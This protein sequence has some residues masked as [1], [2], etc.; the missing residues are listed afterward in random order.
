MTPSS[1][2]AM[3]AVAAS[4]VAATAAW[5][6]WKRQKECPRPPRVV[7]VMAVREEGR[8]LERLLAKDSALEVM[9]LAHLRRVR[10]HVG[11]LR[12]DVVTCGIGE[13]DAATATTMVMLEEPAHPPTAILSVGCAGAHCPEFNAGDVVLGTAVVPMACKMVRADGAHEHV[14]HRLS[15]SEFVT[16]LHL[17]GLARA[18]AL[19]L[20]STTMPAWPTAP[21]RR[22]AIH[23]GKV[24]STETWTQGVPDIR[25][26]H[27]AHGTCCEEM[28]AYGVVRVAG[29]LGSVPVLAIKDIANNE[30]NPEMAATAQETGKGESIILDEIGRRASVVAAATLAVLS[31][32]VASEDT[33]VT[34]ALL[35]L[36]QRARR[37]C[38]D[39]LRALHCLPA[40]VDASA[41]QA[42]A[43]R[44]D[45]SEVRRL[46]A[47]L[48]SDA[49][50]TRVSPSLAPTIDQE[51]AMICTM[52]A[53]DFG[54]GWRQELHAY[55]GQGAWATVKPGVERL[56]E[57]WPTLPA[58]KLSALD[59]ADVSRLWR[60]EGERSAP[61]GP[62]VASLRMVCNELGRN[63]LSRGHETMA[64]FVS[65]C[66]WRHRC[67]ATPASMLVAELVAAF[68]ATFDDR[69]TLRGREVCLYKKAQLVVGE[70]YH[71]FRA[72]DARFAFGDGD[73]LTAFI[74]NVICAVL[75]KEGVICVSESLAASIEDHVPLASG[76][77]EEVA[78]RAAAMVGVEEVVRH[79]SALSGEGLTP[80]ELGNYLWGVLGKKPAYR[81]FNR[82]A[83]KD[84]VFY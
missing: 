11:V 9:P 32:S 73:T 64:S 65:G 62:F 40:T 63:L 51:A 76:S 26:M 16:D 31:R 43:R 74:D 55:G 84:T 72:E 82:H 41:A 81:R 54:G 70:L 83:T 17:L 30:L 19:S 48:A 61:L 7:V 67:S 44:L 27:D 21:D 56:F 60:I 59:D 37:S 14:G 75:R 52:H 8:F 6:I 80:T 78:L 22:P 33:V 45:L 13:V 12:V 35:L 46:G 66:L 50:A 49:N 18:A 57:R 4:C 29:A 68:P 42:F 69:H 2:I 71:R 25:R 3:G 47:S 79:V 5:A 39:A 34:T 36:P 1:R 15:T 23:E 28:E 20:A 24:C 38:A 58:V 77:E 10:G 53:L